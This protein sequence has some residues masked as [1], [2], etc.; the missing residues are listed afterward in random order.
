MG[1]WHQESQRWVGCKRCHPTRSC[2]IGILFAGSR[3]GH[4][5]DEH[6]ALHLALTVKAG[7]RDALGRPFFIG[8]IRVGGSDAAVSIECGGL[9]PLG[10]AAVVASA[11]KK[12]ELSQVAAL[13]YSRSIDPL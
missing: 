5:L 1:R 7:R 9:T 4:D 12:R 10:L 13:A 6:Q 2:D 3:H 8:E 11:C